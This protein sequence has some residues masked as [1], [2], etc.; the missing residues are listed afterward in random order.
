MDFLK[1]IQVSEIPRI[2]DRKKFCQR[3][4]PIKSQEKCYMCH[5]VDENEIK[6]WLEEGNKYL[7]IL[8]AKGI[9]RLPKKC[10]WCQEKIVGSFEEHIS[11]HKKSIEDY[12]AFC[13]QRELYS[14]LLQAY[15]LGRWHALSAT[16]GHCMA[17][18][19]PSDYSCSLEGSTLSKSHC[20]YNFCLDPRRFLAGC[21]RSTTGF[22]LL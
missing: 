19:D 20:I 6:E 13:T 10:P 14:E 9:G 1:K 11:S 8:T 18:I 5:S 17:C 4:C 16:V 12:Y 7:Y 22:I 2:Q 3:F 15:R 21:K